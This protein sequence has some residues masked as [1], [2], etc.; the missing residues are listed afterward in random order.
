MGHRKGRKRDRR[1]QQRGE[2]FE[3]GNP[4][5]IEPG[6]EDDLFARVLM[7]AGDD[8]SDANRG[9][10]DYGRS[11]GLPGIGRAPAITACGHCREFVEDQ[12][13]GRGTCL[14]P[15][16]GIAFPWTDTPGCAFF[17]ARGRR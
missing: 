3:S 4:G 5:L 13:G 15:G 1:A 14:H 2:Q 7:L 11:G 8:I 16:S 9:Y 6:S 12:E 17:A 10:A